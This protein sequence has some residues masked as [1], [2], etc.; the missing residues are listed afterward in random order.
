MDLTILSPTAD[1]GGSCLYLNLDGTGFL[2]DAG[3]DLSR[4]GEA[5]LPDLRPLGNAPLDWILLSHAHL[6]HCGSLPVIAQRW[7]DA[8]V[9]CS[10]ATWEL[11]R[12]QLVRRAALM[13]RAW[14][15]GQSG[16]YPL[17]DE[18]EIG[19]LESRV[20]FIVN[21]QPEALAGSWNPYPTQVT[22]FDAGHILGSQSFLLEGRAGSAFHTGDSC[23]RPQSVIQGAVLPASADVVITGTTLAWSDFHNT[24]KRRDE[25]SR[26]A[27]AIN[28]V[29]AMGGSI[30]LPVFNLG[31]AQ[32]LLFVLHMLKKK[33][34]IQPIP[35]HVGP[36]AWKV[37]AIYDRFAA[38][39]RR[40]LEDFSFS[41][42]LVDVFSDDLLEHS[43]D[44]GS[45]IYLV[46]TGM[47]S[48]GSLARRL[49]R[50]L[51]PHPVHG[52][53]FT[54]HCASGTLGKAVIKSRQG[55]LLDVDGTPV[56]RQCR[57]EEFHFTS[58][59]TRDEL[60]D[61]L[62]RLSP[63][64]AVL[65]PGRKDSRERLAREM[66]IS[67]PSITCLLPEPGEEIPLVD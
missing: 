38:E 6:D 58:H 42:T 31:L 46:A 28:D 27:Q 22:A 64:K 40:L 30:L 10:R 23:L 39:D 57:V 56:M 51:A 32:E 29:T 19:E 12:L 52:V 21:G 53:F 11:A 4:T 55:D 49:F 15:E 1:C 34:R 25:I 14:A 3:C 35:I 36:D 65:L 7:P 26:L 48:L 59:S 33:G 45:E 13:A 16:D 2:L 60:L 8:R 50:R 66:A 41:D 62:G 18:N 37:A 17:Y 61:M 63:A 47:L 54:S 44:R 20:Q 9:L 5:S 67:L 24:L 43:P